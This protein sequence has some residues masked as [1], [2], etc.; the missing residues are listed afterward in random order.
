MKVF[1]DIKA[2]VTKKRRLVLGILLVLLAVII[3]AISRPVVA[4]IYYAR[5]ITSLK[6]NKLAEARQSFEFAVRVYPN[7][8]SAWEEL[9]FVVSA[10]EGQQRGLPYFEKAAELGT[11]NENTW[12]R[13]ISARLKENDFDGARGIIEQALVQIPNSAEMYFLR[14]SIDLS[15]KRWSSAKQNFAEALR[16]DPQN[17]LRY[18]MWTADVLLREGKPDEALAELQQVKD[19]SPQ[20]LS[21]LS[22]THTILG[23][24][25]E[26]LRLALRAKELGP[27]SATVYDALTFV[28]QK[29]GERQKA[30]EALEK[31]LEF[32]PKE[33]IPPTSRIKSAR[34]EL[35]ALNAGF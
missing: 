19:E 5:G 22:T 23:N 13:L 11:K 28:Y 16:R 14:G 21:M 25:Q 33:I 20:L 3:V 26:A 9:G 1:D 15:Q 32:A 7:R 18:R 8:I 29:L 17:E 4:S 2:T 34:K 31:F 35:E 10:L 24:Y 30:I 12:T 6:E 27:E